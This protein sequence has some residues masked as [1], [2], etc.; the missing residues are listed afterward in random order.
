[1]LRAVHGHPEPHLPQAQDAG[2]NG[3]ITVDA[4]FQHTYECDVECCEY[5]E[6]VIESEALVANL[7]MLTK[8][9]SSPEWSASTFEPVKGIKEV[10]LDPSG[11]NS[12]VVRI[13]ATLDP[14]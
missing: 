14:K 2:P 4:S 1:V 6:A 12:W 10:P 5:A 13:S 9:S 3:V 11:C 8:G 7:E